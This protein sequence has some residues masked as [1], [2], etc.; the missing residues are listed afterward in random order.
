MSVHDGQECLIID[1]LV[2]VPIHMI[3]QIFLLILGEGDDLIDA[4]QP[5]FM[6]DESTS[7]LV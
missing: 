2:L 7:D 3:E 1:H 4:A 6:R 5:T